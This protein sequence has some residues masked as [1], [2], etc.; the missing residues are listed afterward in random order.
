MPPR[1]QTDQTR[2]TKMYIKDHLITT[3]LHPYY[4]ANYSLYPNTNKATNEYALEL[5]TARGTRHH[6]NTGTGKQ[7]YK[8]KDNS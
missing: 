5:K 4:K 3:V 2:K 6:A 7:G 8:Q 1:K